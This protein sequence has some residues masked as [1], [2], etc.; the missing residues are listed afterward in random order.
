MVLNADVV[1]NNKG[2][3][4]F[5]V[6]LPAFCSLHVT[7]AKGL[8]SRLESLAPGVVWLVFPRGDRDKVLDRVAEHTHGRGELRVPIRGVAILEYCPLKMICI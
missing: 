8:F 3:K 1:A 4:P 2:K 7:V 6:L 5:G